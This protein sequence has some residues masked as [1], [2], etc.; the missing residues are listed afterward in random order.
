[1]KKMT[2]GQ[3]ADRLE[4]AGARFKAELPEALAEAGEIVKLDAQARIG[5]YQAGWQQLA[6]S[7]QAE[8]VRLGYSANDP[9]LRSGE[10][11]DAVAV[12]VEE[13]VV[14]VGVGGDMA[15][16]A[17]AQEYGTAH[18]PPRPFLRPAML[19]TLPQTGRVIA[20]ALKRAIR[21]E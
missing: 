2:F 10:L 8:R 19:E 12:R 14:A 17:R 13:N 16:I 18:I 1:M 7:T 4:G 5:H 11:R 9:L 6:E 21:G 20:A 15:V 3:L